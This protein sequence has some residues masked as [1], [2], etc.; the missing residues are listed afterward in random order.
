MMMFSRKMLTRGQQHRGL[1]DREVALQDRVDHQLADAGPAEDGLDDD[2]AVDQADGQVAGD[3][4][5]GGGGVA[6]GVVGDDA[7]V[8]GALAAGQPH[9]G[10]GERGNHCAAHHLGE[11]AERPDHQRGDRQD[12]GQ[13]AAVDAGGGQHAEQDREE[14]DA[15]DGEPEVGD[16]DAAVMDSRLENRS[17]SELGR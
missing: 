15:G 14:P 2:R 5:R 7:E 4:Q 13:D 1:Q 10:R 16:A 3:G 11:H 8:A 12:P 9:V 17:A 6:Q